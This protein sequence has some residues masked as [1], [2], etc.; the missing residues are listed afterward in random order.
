MDTGPL[1][2][3]ANGIIPADEIDDGAAAVNAGPRLAERIHAGM[4]APLYQQ[5]LEMART[6][7]TEEYGREVGQLSPAEIARVLAI[8]REKA[9]AFFAQLRLDV[10]TLYLS[11]AGVWRRIG[12]RGRQPKAAGIPTS[13]SHRPKKSS[14]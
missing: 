2:A 14:S 5:G 6:V 4:H 1:A 10:S 12:F 13:I 11:D 8:V 9:P 3:L 7:A